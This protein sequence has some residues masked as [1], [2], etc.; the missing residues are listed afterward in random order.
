MELTPGE[1]AIL[2]QLR[3]L[4]TSTSK[5]EHPL[6]TITSQWLPPLFEAYKGVLSGLVTKGFLRATNQ[7]RSV[8]I[9]AEGLKAMGIQIASA[10][11]SVAPSP[12]PRTQT[13]PGKV[14]ATSKSEPKPAR[15][16]EPKQKPRTSATKIVAFLATAVLAGWLAWRFF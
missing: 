9:T 1:R 10:R 16:P 6:P 5:L 2:G 11:A 3:D 15:H 7:G 8:E 13:V 14:S 12:P 4:Y